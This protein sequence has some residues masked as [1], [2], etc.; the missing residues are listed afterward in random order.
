[1]LVYIS[2]TTWLRRELAVA[3]AFD[4]FLALHLGRSD[5]VALRLILKSAFIAST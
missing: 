5:P 2:L 1:M 4:K 3:L